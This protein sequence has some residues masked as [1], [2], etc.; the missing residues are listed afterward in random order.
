[1]AGLC[2]SYV[3]ELLPYRR[4]PRMSE[5]AINQNRRARSHYYGVRSPRW[6]WCCK[7][8]MS[9]IHPLWTRGR[10][11]FDGLLLCMVS[12]SI[13]A[14]MWA[15]L[16]MAICIGNNAK[17]H[18]HLTKPL[19]QLERAFSSVYK[20]MGRSCRGPTLVRI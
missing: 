13:V 8:V 2:Y 7:A 4:K 1:M 11:V 19:V 15:L 20:R 6:F 9:V 16:A 14:Y 3:M 17:A 5:D 18:D 12:A 10:F